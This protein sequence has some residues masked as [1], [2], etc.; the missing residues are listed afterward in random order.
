MIAAFNRLGSRWMTPAPR[1]LPGTN[2]CWAALVEW[3]K[4][5]SLCRSLPASATLLRDIGLTYG[6]VNYRAF[7]IRTAVGD[8]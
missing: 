7:D 2:G 5:E 4:R 1:H 6:D 8:F 3:R